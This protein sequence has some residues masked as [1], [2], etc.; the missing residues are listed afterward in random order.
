M[1]ESSTKKPLSSVQLLDLI[2]EVERQVDYVKPLLTLILNNPC[3]DMSNQ[4]HFD[5]I[6]RE[7]LTKMTRILVAA[8]N[9][10][11]FSTV[12]FM[13]EDDKGLTRLLNPKLSGPDGQVRPIF[14]GES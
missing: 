2:T 13:L 8:A 7:Q 9:D 12:S 6:A 5:K 1:T 14:R 11:D 3:V 4:L 10:K